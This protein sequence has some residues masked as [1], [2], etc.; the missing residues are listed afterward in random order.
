MA[1]LLCLEDLEVSVQPGVALVPEA[2]ELV[3]ERGSFTQRCGF[4]G[5]WPPL[6]GPA[7]VNESG[8]LEHPE[9]LRDGRAAHAERRSQFL[10]RG[11]PLCQTGE[12][13][14]PGRVG[15]GEEGAA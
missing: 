4:E 3:G 6:G 8:T 12:N 14:P 11:R 15:E 9:V 7:P 10:D 13:G 1:L 5:P 2:A